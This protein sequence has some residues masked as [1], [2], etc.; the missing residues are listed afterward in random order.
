MENWWIIWQLGKMRQKEIIAQAAI[1]RSGKRMRRGRNRPRRT[2]ILAQH[3]VVVF[4]DS[5][6][7]FA[8]RLKRSVQV[9]SV[10]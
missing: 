7:R 4:A 10:P 9:A 5:L 1:Y 2:R 8:E 6:V 3:A